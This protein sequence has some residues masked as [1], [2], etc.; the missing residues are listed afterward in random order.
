[1][2]AAKA[3]RQSAPDDGALALDILRASV[4]LTARIG[5]LLSGLGLTQVMAGGLWAVTDEPT[6]TPMK[7]LAEVLACDRSNATLVAAKLEAAGLAERV[8]DPTDRRVRVLRLTPA[9]TAKRRELVSAIGAASG[10]HR[11]DDTGRRALAEA[12]A[13]V[14]QT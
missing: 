8:T 10:L 1:M 13:Q 2:S 3:E 12:L 5:D 11:L 4:R 9:G 7:Q 6:G 14:L